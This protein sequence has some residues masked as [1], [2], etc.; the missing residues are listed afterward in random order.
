MLKRI[1]YR[2]NLGRLHL[3]PCKCTLA[4][5][6]LAFQLHLEPILRGLSQAAECTKRAR[7]ERSHSSRS[8]EVRG[9]VR[10]V[11]SH[12]GLITNKGALWQRLPCG[13]RAEARSVR[14]IG[15]VILPPLWL[16]QGFL[17][18]SFVLLARLIPIEADAH[19]VLANALHLNWILEVEDQGTTQAA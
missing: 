4:H 16:S 17:V 1:Y 10:S 7:T 8:S 13:E 2:I 19:G 15:W 9:S 3:C 12:R 11:N 18:E 14:K 6:N 5:K